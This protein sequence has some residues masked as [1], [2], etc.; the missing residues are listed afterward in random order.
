MKQNGIPFFLHKAGKKTSNSTGSTSCAIT[1]N[2]ALPS[3]TS[4]VTW[5]KPNLMLMGF[6]PTFFPSFEAFFYS[7]SF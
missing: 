2:L 6:G 5:F 3:S 4:S 1:T 7:A